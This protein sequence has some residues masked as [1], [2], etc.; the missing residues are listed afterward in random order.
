MQWHPSG[1]MFCAGFRSCLYQVVDPR[2]GDSVC[3]WIVGIG[4]GV[5]P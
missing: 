5:D 2:S 3:E 1:N 4:V